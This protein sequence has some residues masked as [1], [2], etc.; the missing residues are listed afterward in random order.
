MSAPTALLTGIARRIAAEGTLTYRPAGQAFQPGEN[1]ITFGSQHPTAPITA[2]L[3][4]Y[5]P[6]DSLT[7]AREARIQVRIRHPDYLAGGDLGETLRGLLHDARYLD[8]D[9]IPVS[10]ITRLSTAPLGLDSKGRHEWTHNYRVLY[11][12]PTSKETP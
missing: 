2:C 8:F 9:G 3:T 12:Q 11:A 5:T 4:D 6:A 10:H 7:R 1:P